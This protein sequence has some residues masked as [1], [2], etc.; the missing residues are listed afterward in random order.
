MIENGTIIYRE[1]KE[2]L[3]QLTPV[4]NRYYSEISQGNEIVQ[5]EYRSQLHENDFSKLLIDSNLKNNTSKS[6]QVG[7]HKDDNFYMNNFP[8]KKIGSQGQQKSFLI[9]LKLAPV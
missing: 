2:F 9:A 8:I 4:F 3:K 7:I 6:T 1:R 5:L